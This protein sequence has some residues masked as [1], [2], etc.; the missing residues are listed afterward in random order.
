M[1]LYENYGDANFFEGGCFIM[2]TGDGDYEVITCDFVN[3]AGEDQYLFC[4]G[5]ICPADSWIDIAAV[6]SACGD[7][8]D[9][10]SLVRDIVAYYGMEQTGAE[11]QILSSAEVIEQMNGYAEEYEFEENTWSEGPL[12]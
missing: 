3:D 12:Y 10:M 2:D 8:R 1:P 5:I 6:K 7:T 11:C 9:D 4:V